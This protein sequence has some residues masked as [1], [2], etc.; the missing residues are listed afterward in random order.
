MRLGVVPPVWSVL[1]VGAVILLAG[2]SRETY[3]ITHLDVLHEGW[4]TLNVRIA[5]AEQKHLGGNERATPD[6]ATALVFDASYDTLYAGPLAPIPIPDKQLGDRENL[7]V[8][9]CGFFGDQT[10]CEQRSIAS[11]PKRLRVASDISYPADPAYTKGSYDLRFIAERQVFGTEKW[12]R[13]DRVNNIKGYLL[14]YVASR[15]AQSLMVPFG[16]NQGRFDLASYEGYRD[17]KYY[18]RSQLLDEREAHVRFDVYAGFANGAPSRLASIEKRVREKSEDD[19]RVELRLFVEQ[20]T[21]ALLEA[22]EVSN[23]NAM[24]YIDDWR[25]DDRTNQYRAELELVW[26]G[27]SFFGSRYEVTGLFTVN[28]DGTEAQ[29]TLY[30]GT[31]RGERYWRGQRLHR[32]VSLGNLKAPTL[33][34]LADAHP[35]PAWSW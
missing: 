2:C 27:R 3:V 34:E 11:S 8:E 24:A 1:L 30:D 10:V 20:A 16:D 35:E 33:E 32:V 19:R 6:T 26:G 9:V 12:E 23:R 13:I 29:F 15:E 28:E 7:M 4:D 21:E 14:A 18:L 22:L 31:R 5:F 17:F 25:Y